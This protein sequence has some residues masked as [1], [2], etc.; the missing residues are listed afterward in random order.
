M[1]LKVVFI[2]AGNLASQLSKA[3]QNN[4]FKIIQVYSRSKKSATELAEILSVSYTTN[5]KE[6]DKNADIYFIALK[7][8]VIKEVLAQIDFQ[9]KLIVH[10]S[11]SLP[12]SVLTDYSDNCGVF[13]PLQT[14]TKSRFVDF[15][16][17][18]VFIESEKKENEEL[19]KSIAEK[20][21]E[22]VE[23]MGSEQRKILHVSAV[24]ACNF[25][26]YMYTVAADIL[27][28]NNISFDVI[29]PLI[30]ET[31]RKVQEMEP[32]LAQ[33]GPA[34]RFDENVINEHLKELENFGDYHE[35]YKSISKRIFEHHKS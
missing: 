9:N 16:E 28:S 2:G 23:N 17:I 10:C 29:K 4:G 11:G 34:V 24:F 15:S 31:A 5:I 13:Y 18:P 30:L 3:I 19:L 25:V 6:I 22:K 20:V 1:S 26:N 35:L 8:S 33:T 21:S 7:D 14:F 12:L 32:V 27:K